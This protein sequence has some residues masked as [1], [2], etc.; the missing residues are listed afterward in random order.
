MRSHSALVEREVGTPVSNAYRFGHLPEDRRFQAVMQH[1]V[2][3]HGIA[4][5]LSEVGEKERTIIHKKPSHT[6]IG[7]QGRQEFLT[8][9]P[10]STDNSAH[11]Y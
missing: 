3:I 6:N 9:N 7:D 11:T 2:S 5:S 1:H 10:D 4:Y 8:E